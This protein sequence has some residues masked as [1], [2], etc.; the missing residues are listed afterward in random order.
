VQNLRQGFFVKY[1]GQPY[2][3]SI[4]TT[5]DKEGLSLVSFQQ[6]VT[7]AWWEEEVIESSRLSLWT[8]GIKQLRVIAPCIVL[9]DSWRGPK[10]K[11]CPYRSY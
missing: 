11:T 10:C 8:E 1:E 2:K 5:N 4:A 3:G 7:K 6:P 9:F